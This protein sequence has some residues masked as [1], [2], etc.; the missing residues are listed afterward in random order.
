MFTVPQGAEYKFQITF[1]VSNGFAHAVKLT[2]KLILSLGNQIHAVQLGTYAPTGEPQT[3]EYPRYG[4]NQAPFGFLAR[5]KYSN[6]MT[7]TA[8][9]NGEPVAKC[10]YVLQ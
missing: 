1:T 2:N 5:G 3:C 8:G 7:F 4:W 10:D 6:E 9:E